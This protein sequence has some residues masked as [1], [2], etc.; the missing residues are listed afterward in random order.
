[1]AQI[2]IRRTKEVST[3]N[4]ILLAGLRICI[5]FQMQDSTTGKALVPLP[6][7]CSFLKNIHLQC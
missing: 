1:M 6:P 3:K 7:V 4:V 5:I 2:C